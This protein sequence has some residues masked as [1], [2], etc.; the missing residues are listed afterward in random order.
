MKSI[1]FEINLLPIISLLAVCISFLL[2]TAV[3][4]PVGGVEVK[5]AVGQQ[6]I[7][8]DSSDSLSLWLKF[9][10]DKKV[11]VSVLDSN[12]QAV[13][14]NTSYN[15]TSKKSI[16]NLIK[17]LIKSHPQITNA[18]V[19]PDRTTSLNS[20]ISIMD[21]IKSNNLKN[22]GIAPIQG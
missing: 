20:I 12:M 10:A 8:E 18:I 13:V 5:Q 19:A 3:W 22:V 1:D 2:V 11:Q 4:V 6:T 16:E 15:T 21:L 7:N 14:E 17:N 9:S